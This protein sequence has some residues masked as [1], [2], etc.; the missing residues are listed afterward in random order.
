[1]AKINVL[2]SK[3]YNRIAAGEVVERPA[4]VVKELVENSIDAGAKNITVEIEDGGISCIR[5]IDDGHGIEKSELKKALLP[6]ATSKISSLK[7]L[8]NITSLGFRG[9]A[10]AS[11][12]SVSKIKIVSKPVSQE[13]GASIFTETGEDFI[14]EDCGAENGTEITVRNLFFN[15]PAREKFLKTP[16]SE[17]GEITAVMSRVIMCNPDISFKYVTNDKTVLQSYGDGFKSAVLCVYGKDFLDNLLEID[18]ERN[19]VIIKGLIGSHSFTKGN[20]SYQTV[21]L[22]GRYVLNQTI[23]TAIYNAYSSYMMKRQYPVYILNI[24]VPTEIVDVNVHP[25]KIDVRFSNNQIIYGS[26]YSSI[27]K[28]LDGIGESV[29]IKSNDFIN[30]DKQQEKSNEIT[31][32]YARHNNEIKNYSTA[33]NEPV[34]L[35]K[36]YFSDVKKSISFDDE[37]FASKSE[38][39]DVFAENKKFLEQ[40]EQEK[41]AKTQNLQSEITI[42]RDLRYIGQA[43]NTYLL[44]DDGVDFYIADQHACHERILFDKINS[45][46]NKSDLVTQPLLVPFVLDLNSL[47]FNFMLDKLSVMNKMGIEI[48]EFGRN[49]LRVTALPTFLTNLNL[50]SFFNDILAE[51]DSFKD[52]NVND[53]LIEKISQKACKAAVKSG[54]KLT[55]YDIEILLKALQDNP[56]LKCPHGRPVMVKI[57]RTEID[58]WFKRIV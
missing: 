4:S 1:M 21:F 35:D 28:R 30:I 22:N 43:L 41:I 46:Y 51:K 48:E 27:T 33:K 5:I 25:N 15:T 24:N 18:T 17:E 9:E 39:V 12:A 58:K 36:I 50:R 13:M 20:K 29:A 31:N 34:K 57:S 37:I 26:I 47:E 54:D 3:I 2:S 19:G 7:D 45:S 10:L 8:D 56:A 52:F 11:I 14:I 6:H 44:F 53:L 49:A 42:N 55:D 16:R 40:L 38:S 23:S 32:D